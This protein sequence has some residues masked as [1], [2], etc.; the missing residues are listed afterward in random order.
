MNRDISLESILALI[1]VNYSLH[2]NLKPISVNKAKP[3]L[4][5]DECSL[6]FV[7]NQRSDKQYLIQNSLAGIVICDNEVRTFQEKPERTC[8][9]IVEKPKEVFAEVVNSIYKQSVIYGIHPSAIVSPNAKIHQNVYIGPNTYVGESSIG[10]GSVIYGNTYI[11]DNVF[12]GKSVIV[13]ACSSIGA[14]GFGYLKNEN[15][16]SYNFPHIGGV[17][18]E[19]CV[20]IGSN[21]CIDR[22]ALG[23]TH[24]K[25][26]AKI[27]NLVHIAHNVVVGRNAWIIANAMIG[28]STVIED[29][30]YIAPSASVRD[31]VNIGMN[32]VVGM[33]AVVTKNVPADQTWT[34][35]PAKELKQFIEQQ[36]KIKKL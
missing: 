23:N 31:V 14:A 11:Y 12:I 19:D 24:I 4:E 9:I 8:Y 7:N 17:V 27:D 29:N 26:G 25:Y 13:N 22:G 21:T 1:R 2:G 35:N 16:D 10:E 3:I 36:E 5:A 18:I 30:A 32:S 34:G 20:E 33:G 28:G 15:G 6:S